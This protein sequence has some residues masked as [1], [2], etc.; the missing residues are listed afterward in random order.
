MKKKLASIRYSLATKLILAVGV[1]LLLS[2]SIWAYFNINYQKK[3]VMDDIVNQTD[4]LS[5]TIK[6]GTHYSMMLNSR[7]DIN[8]IITNIGRQEEILGIRIYNKEGQIKF[9][10]NIDEIDR[11]ADI[12]AGV[13]F[14]CHREVLPLTRL[15]LSQRIR[16]TESD[17]GQR[18][19]GIISPIYNEPGCATGACHVHPHDKKVLGVLDV[20]VSL[21]RTDREIKTFERG[22]LVL[23]GFVFLATSGFIFFI[24]YRFVK[25]P[26][27]K[28]VR[29]TQ[30]IA[31]GER[32]SGGETE[33][34]DD[35]GH[36]SAAISK[37]GREIRRKQDELKKQRD[38]YQNLFELVPCIITI[39]DRNYK[40]LRYNSEFADKFNPAPGDFCYHVYKGR[41]TKCENCPVEKTFKEG[42]SH[43]GEEQG[44]NKDGS[45]THWVAKTS[46]IRDP[47]GNIVSVMEVCLDITRRRELE[48]RLERSEQKYHLIFEH[49][50]M[51]VFMLDLDTLN[52]LDCND[53]MRG[54][55]GYEKDELINTCFLELFREADRDHYAFKILTSSLIVQARQRCR[56]GRIIIVNIRISPTEY[57]GQRVLLAITSDITKRLETEQQLIQAGKMATLGEMATGIAHELNQPLSVIKTA[58]SFFMKKIRKNEPI[59]PDILLSL[60][61]EIDHHVDRAAKI[62]NHMR[63]FGRKSDL[64]FEMVRVNDVLKK[65][66]EIFSRQLR[67]RGIDVAWDLADDLPPV[68]GEPC[69]LEQVFINLLI[70]ARDAIED[71]W[72][73]T[74][75]DNLLELS[76]EQRRITI[77]SSLED[78]MVRVGIEDT[79]RGVSPEIRDKIFEPF[80]TTKEVGKGTGL[81]LSISYSIIRDCHGD[82]EVTKGK[83]GGAC[84]VIRFP[85][86]DSKSGGIK[87]ER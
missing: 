33:P 68:M 22:I 16:I 21:A 52:I 74:V 64:R 66:I 78:N 10:G 4:R 76:P 81:G 23:A 45:T 82:I 29:S 71:R 43:Y 46:P 54:V 40:L 50:P 2:V 28:L 38:K 19:L 27:N 84:F 41:N 83:R 42:G 37:M 63:Q 11:T 57:Q 49:I 5:T 24:V 58:S 17:R 25:Q 67:L 15:D 59:R 77:R 32:V 69:R 36:L 72:A 56:N 6:L 3:R 34:R 9:A 61:E 14:V 8:Q 13:C 55:Y 18:R 20:V 44:I 60:S 51:P 80:F 75:M 47:D 85:A 30:R 79:G 62:I 39:Q 65:A 70:N 86:A 1:V 35:M 12:N 87:D 31:L 73:G 48:K 53:S 7:D 26:I